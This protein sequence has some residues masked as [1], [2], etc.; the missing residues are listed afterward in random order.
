MV[1]GHRGAL[2]VGTPDP[3]DTLGLQALFFRE[4]RGMADTHRHNKITAPANFPR[5]QSQQGKDIILQASRSQLSGDTVVLFYITLNVTI[6][7]GSGEWCEVGI[8]K[9]LEGTRRDDGC[10]H[11]LDCDDSFTGV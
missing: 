2:Q 5:L 7:E 1:S 6:S 4:T 8:A 11:K 10:D 9:G 3:T